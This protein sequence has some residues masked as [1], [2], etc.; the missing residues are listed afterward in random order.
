LLKASFFGTFAESMWMPLYAMFVE[1]VGGNVLDAGIGY[2]IF[3]IV[4]GTVVITYGKSKF[5]NDHLAAHIFW[6]FAISGI[7]D[8]LLILVTTKWSL[9]LVF[10]L[11]GVTVGV[12]NP[13]WDALYS[14]DIEK[15]DGGKKWSLWSGGVT[16]FSGIAALL[17]GVIVRLHGFHTMFVVMTIVDSYAV[18]CS[19][20]VWKEFV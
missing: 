3:E 20:R 12:L 19:Y 4:T 15:G 8:L 6:G 5:F 9:Y 7:G 14:D 1:K 13:A 10:S 17:A 16:F 2:A 11:I 18:W